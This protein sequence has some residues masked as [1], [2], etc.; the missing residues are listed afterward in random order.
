MGGI[1]MKIVISGWPQQKTRDSTWKPTKT[2]KD[3]EPGSS[4]RAL[5]RQEQGSEFKPSTVKNNKNNYHVC[6]SL[7]SYKDLKNERQ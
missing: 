3:W 2:K 4:N 1:G 6:M 5:A 7:F